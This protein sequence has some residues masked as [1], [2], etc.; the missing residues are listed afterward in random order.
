M[1]LCRSIDVIRIIG[2][3]SKIDAF[4]FIAIPIFGRIGKE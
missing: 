4:T 2:I 1:L 3:I